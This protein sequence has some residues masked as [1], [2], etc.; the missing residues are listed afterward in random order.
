MGGCFAIGH[1]RHGCGN[2]NCFP[3][4]GWAETVLSEDFE[5]EILPSAWT[6]A[7]DWEVQNIENYTEGSGYCVQNAG[8]SI[9]PLDT[10]QLP[11]TDF[12]HYSSVYLYFSTYF[13]QLEESKTIRIDASSDGGFNWDTVWEQSGLSYMGEEAVDLSSLLGGVSVGTV[14]FAYEDNDGNPDSGSIWQMDDISLEAAPSPGNTISGTVSDGN[15]GISGVIVEAYSWE[16]PEGMDYFFTETDAS[17]NYS[18]N[19]YDGDWEIGIILPSAIWV[20]PQPRTVTLGG[21]IFSQEVSFTLDQSPDGFVSGQILSPAGT[22]ITS[23]E[24]PNYGIVID[25]VNAENGFWY[26]ANP[27]SAGN[28]SIPLLSGIYEI[29]VWVDPDT[30]PDYIAPFIDEPV[31]LV[32]GTVPVNIQ[33]LSENCK[34]AGTVKKD[35]V[36]IPGVFVD[37]WNEYGEWRYDI[38]DQ[39][40][41]FEVPVYP[42]TW[43]VSPWSWGTDAVLFTG[44]PQEKTVTSGQTA[45]ADFDMTQASEPITGVIKDESGTVLTAIDAWVYAREEGSPNPIAETW[46]ENGKFRLNVPPGNY[47]VGLYLWPDSGYRFD[48]ASDEQIITQARSKRMAEIGTTAGAA[49]AELSGQEKS[50]AAPSGRDK[51]SGEQIVFILKSNTKKIQG[52]FKNSG[53]TAITGISGYV[54][55]DRVNQSGETAVN[56]L[57]WH[58]GE[59]NSQTGGFEIPVSA[60]KWA[61]SYSL[62]S[63]PENFYNTYRELTEPILVTVAET[64]QTIMQNIVLP[65]LG[66]GQLCGTVYYPDGTTP[67]PNVIVWLRSSDLDITDSNFMEYQTRSD[68]TGRF[69][70]SL[71]NDLPDQSMAV[72]MAVKPMDVPGG[73]RGSSRGN[74]GRSQVISWPRK[75]RSDDLKLALREVN[76]EIK[77]K[78]MRPNGTDPASG[79]FVY[80]CSADGQKT[81][82]AADAN[83]SF[84]LEAARAESSRGNIWRVGAI[85]KNPDGTYSRTKE[86]LCT[87]SDT[88]QSVFAV[89]NMVLG[90]S[91]TMMASATHTFL[92]EKG[93]SHTLA[94]G[95]GIQIPDGAIPV[96]KEVK[97]VKISVEPLVRDLP[98]TTEDRVVGYGYGITLRGKEDGREIVKKFSK[99]A[100]VILRYT[101]EQLTELGIREADLRPAYFLNASRSWKPLKNFT[102]DTVA[103]KIT[104]RTDHFS[105]WALVA[106]NGFPEPGNVNGSSESGG[107]VTLADAILSLQICAGAAVPEGMQ[108]FREAAVNDDLKIGTEE[109]VYILQKV[110]NLR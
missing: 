87:T 7:G 21:A 88:A 98:N 91:K 61:L 96:N 28:Y 5:D 72:G 36:G 24:S 45:N 47:K 13:E 105:T 26:S 64:D 58:M 110:A 8:T 16:N 62:F 53:G 17:G 44:L 22:A 9:I 101:D 55:A 1:Q 35:T 60:G 109:A 23:T 14:R 56:S 93:W 34:I 48:P 50:L 19:V 25:A 15:G 46:V 51:R 49:I 20:T 104:F 38:T 89:G 73:G 71:P 42:G 67:A 76:M 99:N 6:A 18:L 32:A 63:V 29:S 107:G 100:T 106:K 79:A 82:A 75:K 4:S 30:Y 70:F 94:D 90:S 92:P 52:V 83:G 68:E 11:V 33:L 103:N 31:S 84:T 2:G 102:I 74:G 41:Y 97:Q 57:A 78:I 40:G 27:D 66:S 59:I 77:G 10:L 108:I 43:Y 86:I 80:A 65:P 54:F 3:L 85:F 69:C 81:D 39:N 37:V 12:S 95:T